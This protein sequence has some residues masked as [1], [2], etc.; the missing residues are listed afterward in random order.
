MMSL[1][2]SDEI[3]IASISGIMLL[4]KDGQRNDFTRLFFGGFWGRFC[5][6]ALED[7]S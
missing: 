3:C 4:S 7:S 6:V 2:F 1:F 5:L